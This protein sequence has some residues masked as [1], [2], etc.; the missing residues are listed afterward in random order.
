ME[1][2]PASE[3]KEDCTEQRPMEDRFSEAVDH[4]K[5]RNSEVK[6]SKATQEVMTHSSEDIAANKANMR[7]GSSYLSRKSAS[8]LERHREM[9]EQHVQRI[10]NM[11]NMLSSLPQ[12][13]LSPNFPPRVVADPIMPSQGTLPMTYGLQE[14]RELP[15]L[16]PKIQVRCSSSHTS[17]HTPMSRKGEIRWTDLAGNLHD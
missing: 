9:M 10:N 4:F 12:C 1:V 8:D 15:A 7:L 5:R 2:A 14:A 16:K 11:F 3:I 17:N 6:E 13:Q